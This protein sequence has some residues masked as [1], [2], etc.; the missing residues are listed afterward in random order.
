MKDLNRISGDVLD[1]AVRI[2]KEFGPGM[3]ESVYEKILAIELENRGHQVECQKPLALTYGGRT[4]PEAF[5]VDLLV[6]GCV[7]VELKSTTLMAPVYF[8]QLR[9]YLVLSGLQVGLLVN[10]GMN[11][12]KEG[13]KRIVNNYGTETRAEGRRGAGVGGMPHAESAEGAERG[14][15][16]GLRAGEVSQSFLSTQPLRPPRSLREEKGVEEKVRV[17]SRVGGMPHAENAESAERR[18]GKMPLWQKFSLLTLLLSVG[19]C[20]TQEVSYGRSSLD[21]H[22]VDSDNDLLTDFEERTFTLTDPCNADTDGDGL[23]DG[24][25][26]FSGLDP[27]CPDGI[28]GAAGDPFDEGVTNM[29]RFRQNPGRFRDRGLFFKVPGGK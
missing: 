10:F 18:E 8:K 23:P 1:A 17:E 21:P 20:M 15:V 13:F 16:S 2:H 7:V 28:D 29:E 14:G 25:E 6:D 19:G 27:L 9:T 22:P 4:F 24:W 26:Y 12:L 3:M 5:R 11:T